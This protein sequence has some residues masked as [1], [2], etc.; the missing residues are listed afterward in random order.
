MARLD[1]YVLSQ[2][3]R[4][5][6]FFSLVLV[7]LYWINRAVILFDQLI[8]DGHS[9][10]VFVE[11]SI[12]TLPNAIRL[13][14]PVAAFAAAVYVANRMR[15]ESE[16]VVMQSAGIS[17]L[18]GL[19]PV[20]VF[21]SVALVLTLVLGHV[22]SP[23]SKER[24]GDRTADLAQDVTA[25]LLTEGQFLHPAA[26]VT[27][28]ITRITPEGELQGLFLADRRSVENRTTY[29]AERA[30]LLR[31]EAGPRIVMFD[32]LAQT[33]RPDGRLGTTRF[34]DF[35]FDISDLVPEATAQ[36]RA[37]GEIATPEIV[38]AGDRIAEE[39]GETSRRIRIEIAERTA[40]GLKSL[41]APL[42]G[43][44]VMMTGGYSRFTA[45]R[46]I[47]AAIVALI[48]YDLAGNLVLDLT[49]GESAPVASIY[50]P[51]AVFLSL[52]LWPLR[53]AGRTARP[54]RRAA[55]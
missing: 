36:G 49:L 4:L 46:Q 12:L 44:A 18:R 37:I 55:A 19:M 34:E 47:L 27:L 35:A 16:L 40:Q 1:R 5:F 54:R 14:L 25:G 31:R 9:A 45:W 53:A 23:L 51:A 20:A 24:L 43:F 11:L 21:G 33:L 2:M 28:F 15:A 3:L 22:L 52:T 39:T 10:L 38:R 29:V 48:L 30:L 26:G 13:V 6:G 41:I 8:S 32:G 17:P 50:L 42:L 7:G